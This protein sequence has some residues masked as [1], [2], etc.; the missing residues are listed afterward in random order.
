MG[1][2]FFKDIDS[3]GDKIYYQQLKDNICSYIDWAFLETGAFFN[4]R[5]VTSGGYGGNRETLHKV[6][7]PRYVSG[8]I[9]EGNRKNWIWESGLS[10]TAQQPIQISGIFI[11]NTFFSTTNS[12]VGYYIDYPNG[13]VV[14]NTAMP[15][16]SS[17]K[18]EYSCKWVSI[19]SAE[20]IDV[21]EIQPRSFRSDD[22][23]LSSGSGIW[24][25]LSDTR[26][27]LPAICIGTPIVRNIAGFDLGHS[28]EVETD[29]AIHI[30][31]EDEPTATKLAGILSNQKEQA[32]FLFD[33]D[34]LARENKIPLNYKGQPITN[35]MTYPMLI[36]ASG[37]GGYRSEDVRYGQ[38]W[39]S[40]T[41]NQGYRQI[42]QNIYHNP[43]T[44]TI[45]AIIP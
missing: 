11:N 35:A 29:T 22:A 37:D 15:A 16:H 42:N 8:R 25:K 44:W 33:S 18:L 26:L 38:V 4:I 41:D 20:N 12:S 17:V 3:I 27:Q 1:T 43:V 31:A 6:D 23:R 45:E 7:D 34:R 9:W 21:L 14:F 19:V 10:H 2:T 30:L 28:K 5:I 39:I 40:D 13:R 36:Q 32:L 24:N